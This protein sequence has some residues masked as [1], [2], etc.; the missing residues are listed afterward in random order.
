MFMAVVEVSCLGLR[1]GPAREP[2][3]E[4]VSLYCFTGPEASVAA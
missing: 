3:T 1:F 4:R 2:L